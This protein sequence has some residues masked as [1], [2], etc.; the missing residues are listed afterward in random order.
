MDERV[1]T[2][3]NGAPLRLRNDTVVNVAQLLQEHVGAVRRIAIELDWFALDAD[4]MAK[5]VQSDAR[6]TRIRNGILGT[7]QL[8]GVAMVE[9][10]R[11]LELFEQPFEAEF[12]QEYQPTVD[13]RSGQPLAQ[14]EPEAEIAPINEL[15]E[16]DL[17]EPLRQTAILALPM[18]PICREDCLGVMGELPD[19]DEVGDRR[20]G[21]LEQ[22]LEDS[23]ISNE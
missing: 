9:C 7:G 22:L 11:C 10:V 17:A 18:M 19:D 21:V 16:L 1:Q 8:R 20:L 6:L 5:D 4:L 3:A 2:G 23:R 15:H 13:V 14:P 12:D